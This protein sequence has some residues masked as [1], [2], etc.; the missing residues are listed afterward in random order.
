MS[1]Q[2]ARI[3]TVIMAAIIAGVVLMPGSVTAQRIFVDPPTFAQHCNVKD[4]LW[5]TLDDQLAGVEGVNLNVVFDQTIGRL[6]TILV[7]TAL[8]TN[9]FLSYQV[10]RPDSVA[11]DAGI[12]IG[13][14]S[15]PGA[16]CGLVVTLTDQ[17]GSCPIVLARSILR[18]A[19]NHDIIHSTDPGAL[20]NPC[21]CQYHGVMIDDGF[22]D[23]FDIVELIK[24]VFSGGAAPPQD[25][26]CPH[27][28][29][30]DVTCDGVPDVFDVVRMIDFVFSGGSPLCDPCACNPYPA[31]CP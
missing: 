10:Y 25:A 12:L 3:G 14:F 2:A 29:R 7:A 28:N 4:T 6:D 21:C 30:S 17:L 11:I 1:N 15:G 22:F 13:S 5:I 27:I 9:V 19:D 20:D 18:D 24:Y 23:V 16:L 26:G 31:S 8:D